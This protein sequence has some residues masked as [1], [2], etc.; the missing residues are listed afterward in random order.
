MVVKFRD[1]VIYINNI[2]KEGY[3]ADQFSIDPVG[4]EDMELAFEFYT[5]RTIKSLKTNLST[6]WHQKQF[7][8]CPY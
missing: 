8:N 2:T 6:F 4:I 5:I 3:F 1:K 7:S